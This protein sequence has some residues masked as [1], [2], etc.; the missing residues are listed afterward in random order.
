MFA[1]INREGAVQQYPYSLQELRSEHPN[2]SFPSNME[3]NLA[4]LSD[5]GVVRVFSTQQ[6]TFDPYAEKL[7]E[8]QPSNASGRWEQCWKVVALTEDEIA[9]IREDK[10]AQARALRNR[11]LIESDWTQVADAPVDKQAWADYRQALRDITAQVGFPLNIQW[12]AL[13]E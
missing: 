6:P 3:A 9:Y 13:P 1:K 8:G 11:L 5:F 2:T 10:A 12:P 4:S 7:I